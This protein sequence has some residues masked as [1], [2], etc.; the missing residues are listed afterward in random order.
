VNPSPR[1]YQQKPVSTSGGGHGPSFVGPLNIA[2]TAASVRAWTSRMPFRAKCRIVSA[3]FMRRVCGRGAIGDFWRDLFPGVVKRLEENLQCVGI[4]AGAPDE[5]ARFHRNSLLP[6]S[7]SVVFRGQRRQPQPTDR[8]SR[9]ER[10]A[11][12]AGLRC[13]GVGEHGR[14]QSTTRADQDHRLRK[15]GAQTC[16]APAFLR[17]TTI[18]GTDGRN[19]VPVA[20]RTHRRWP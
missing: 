12:R 19:R 15:N 13:A 16:A 11:A 18:L 5:C 6:R 20:A 1:V 3:S 7:P 9:S 8:D 2:C 14:C 4:V 10:I 17:R